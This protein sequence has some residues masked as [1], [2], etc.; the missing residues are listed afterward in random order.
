MNV[1]VL[2]RLVPHALTEG[3]VAGHA[4]IVD[5]GEMA[6]FKDQGEMLA[7]LIRAA[8]SGGH[9]QGGPYD[10]STTP[11]PDPTPGTRADP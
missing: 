4:E 6:V 3:R 2:L 8:A 10:P 5:T 7:L 11:G 1:S 9:D